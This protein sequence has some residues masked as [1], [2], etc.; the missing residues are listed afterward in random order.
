MTI[1]RQPDTIEEAL[2][3]MGGTL[4][5]ARMAQECG[6]SEST[7]RKSSNPFQDP[8]VPLSMDRAIQLDRLWMRKTGRAPILFGVFLRALEEE[9]HASVLDPD[10]AM[11]HVAQEMSEAM[12]AHIS[13]KSPDG[14]GGKAATPSELL[15]T[16]RELVELVRRGADAIQAVRAQRLASSSIR[17]A[18]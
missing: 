17:E 18:S 6:V 5:W 8:P 3:I 7:L 16:E 2:D 1:Q 13:A 12:A 14:P 9:D 11:H 4:G 15:A 10:T